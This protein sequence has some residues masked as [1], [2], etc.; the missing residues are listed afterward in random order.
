MISIGRFHSVCYHTMKAT[1]KKRPLTKDL[2]MTQKEIGIV[3]EELIGATRVDLTYAYPKFMEMSRDLIRYAHIARV[4]TAEYFLDDDDSYEEFVDFQKSMVRVC[5]LHQKIPAGIDNASV[6]MKTVPEEKIKEFTKVYNEFRESDV[7][8]K[9]F[10][11]ANI[12]SSYK[13]QLD[14]KD[15]KFIYHSS[16]LYYKPFSFIPEFDVFRLKTLP[17]DDRVV[18]TWISFMQQTYVIGDNLARRIQQPDI[19]IK[20]FCKTVITILTAAEKE[21]QLRGCREAF[22]TIKESMDLLEKNFGKYYKEFINADK[23]STSIFV[24]FIR[25]VSENNK[26]AKVKVVRQFTQILNFYVEQMN[27]NGQKLDPQI[28]ELIKASQDMLAPAAEKMI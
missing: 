4:M 26:D 16:G 27:K 6:F 1:Y 14:T 19:D 17:Q 28:S 24:S 18:K 13:A 12:L 23:N 7:I 9:I 11:T 2:N 20:T 22:D 10:T 8:K 3:F 5:E 21:P 25:D 15:S